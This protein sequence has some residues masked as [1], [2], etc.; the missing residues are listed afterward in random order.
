MLHVNL[1]KKAEDAKRPYHITLDK[2]T[3]QV[4]MPVSIFI[5]NVNTM[6]EDAL[7][8]M[9]NAVSAISV[10][11]VP[12]ASEK[13]LPPYMQGHTESFEAFYKLAVSDKY[14]ND[15]YGIQ[16]R[17]TWADLGVLYD[18]IRPLLEP[19]RYHPSTVIALPYMALTVHFATHVLPFL[20]VDV[21]GNIKRFAEHID[22]IRNI[23]R[24]AAA[25]QDHALFTQT[26]AY[27]SIEGVGDL[28]L[29]S[30]H[31]QPPSVQQ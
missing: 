24:Y 8:H 23:E 7:G 17:V 18:R 30:R 4:T 28:P 3:S 27:M 25:P 5:D 12:W 19:L 20:K 16:T 11:N 26:G 14:F 15:R 21:I 2:R 29:Q 9:H 13:N 31:A 6:R 1:Q 22:M 10:G